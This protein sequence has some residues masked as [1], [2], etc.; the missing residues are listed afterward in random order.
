MTVQKDQ[1]EATRG[2][3]GLLCFALMCLSLTI[4]FVICLRSLSVSFR[5]IDS[6]LKQ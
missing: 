3:N 1:A 2:H 4:L 6:S 5:F